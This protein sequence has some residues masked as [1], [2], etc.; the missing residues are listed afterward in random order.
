ME[1]EVASMVVVLR[2]MVAVAFTAVEAADSMV[3]EAEDMAAVGDTGRAF[4][5]WWIR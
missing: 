4:P 2:F 3:E 1:E 5:I